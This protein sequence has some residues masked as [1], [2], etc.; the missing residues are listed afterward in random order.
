MSANKP[1]YEKNGPSLEYVRHNILNKYKGKII[2]TNDQC[3]KMKQIIE[4]NITEELSFESFR[5]YM[6]FYNNNKNKYIQTIL[7]EYNA[8]LCEETN[9][10]KNHISEI[11]E[12]NDE[13]IIILNNFD[14]W[15]KKK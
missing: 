10:Y 14:V 2:K 8:Y 7:K 3:V 15:N 13:D 12:N 4:E 9:E 6:K 1:W 11:L 5:D